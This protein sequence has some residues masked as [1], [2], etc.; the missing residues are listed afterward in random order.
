MSM[1]DEGAKIINFF[2]INF[3]LKGANKIVN[4]RVT[5]IVE[6]SVLDLV[7]SS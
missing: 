1:K 7:M 4:I 5:V 6:L 3:I 2:V